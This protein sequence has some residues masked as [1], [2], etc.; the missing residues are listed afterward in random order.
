MPTQDITFLFVGNGN[1]NKNKCKSM[2]KKF[3]KA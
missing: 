2:Y 1:S 3:K